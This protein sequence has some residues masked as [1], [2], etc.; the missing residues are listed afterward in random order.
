M[1]TKSIMLLLQTVNVFKYVLV[2]S[3]L[4]M[5]INKKS[6]QEL[7]KVLWNPNC[8]F[9]VH[10]VRRNGFIRRDGVGLGLGLG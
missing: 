4:F 10:L 9:G 8:Y 7:N 3:I 1:S 5:W 2:V 6:I